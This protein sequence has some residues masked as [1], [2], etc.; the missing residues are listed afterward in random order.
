MS[1]FKSPMWLFVII[2]VFSLSFSALAGSAPKNVIFFIGD[3]MGPNYVKLAN[4]YLGK[5][6]LSFEE[7][8]HQ[9]EVT[10]CS[11]EGSL[12]DGTCDPDTAHVTDSAAAASAMATGR[13]VKNGVLSIALPGDSK[14]IK[15]ILEHFAELGRSTGI[16]ST[17]MMTDATPAGFASHVQN[18]HQTSEII[19]SY[20]G[21]TK[22]NVIFGGSEANFA[23]SAQ[24]ANYRIAKG[25]SGL[26]QMDLFVGAG[27]YR[28]NGRNCPHVFAGFGRHQ[29]IPGVVTNIVRS[30]PTEI[31]DVGYFE[32][33][34]L[35]HFSDMVRTSLNFL[36]QNKK[37]FFLM[38]E[39]GL[40]DKIGHYHKAI[41]E[42]AGGVNSL[43]AAIFEMLELGRAVSVA[44]EY[45]KGRDDTLIIVSADHETGGLAID[46]ENT[47]CFGTEGCVAKASWTAP[48]YEDS[49]D[50]AKHTNVNVPVYAWGKNASLFDGVMN[51]TDFFKKIKA[52][53]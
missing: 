47:A 15:T 2:L 19:R 7:F 40:I 42:A 18:R 51:N 6:R 43:E 28:C 50:V 46:L 12:P 16:V 39:S 41:D 26:K 23:R 30:I 37:G 45:A 44:L 32:K 13:K 53:M 1:K 3:G 20:F 48:F 21:A 11:Y 4:I 17:E 29:L 27:E 31:S 49:A 52:E 36:G 25:S 22:P 10:T 34:D 38:A 9:G 33:H 24:D 8:L 5:E 14:P 35:P